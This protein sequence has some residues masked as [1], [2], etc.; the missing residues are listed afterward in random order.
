VYVNGRFSGVTDT[1]VPRTDVARV[2]PGF[3]TTPGFSI[4]VAATVGRNDVCVFA[5]NAGPGTANTLLGCRIVDVRGGDPRGSLDAATRSGANVVLG[6][7]ALDPDT[8]SPTR[9]HVYVNGRFVTDAPAD[10][11]RPDVARSFPG[12]GPDHGYRVSVAATR[13]ATICVFALNASGRGTNV[14]LAC[15]PAP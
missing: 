1:G 15:R 5:I 13:G 8:T 4:D 9:V 11:S 2:H 10:G 3:G 12:Y 7:W 6:G 14:L